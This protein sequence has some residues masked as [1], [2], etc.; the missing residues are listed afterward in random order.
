LRLHGNDVR[1]LILE[2]RVI[3][4]GML[5]A[6]AD[7]GVRDATHWNALRRKFPPTFFN[8][9]A[10]NGKAT[11]AEAL[12]LWNT[13]E[14]LLAVAPVSATSIAPGAAP[15]GP[16]VAALQAQVDSLTASL[17]AINFTGRGG[18]NQGN[19][20]GKPKNP[21]PRKDPKG[22]KNPKQQQNWYPFQGFYAPP[23]PYSP[24]APQYT[25]YAPPPPQFQQQQQQFQGGRGN[26]FRGR[27]NGRGTGRGQAQNNP[28]PA[29]QQ[30]QTQGQRSVFNPCFSCGATDH[31]R[32]DCPVYQAQLICSECGKAGHISMVCQSKN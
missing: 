18:G 31:L 1:R 11:V 9:L 2:Y 4:A 29:N 21:K 3:M 23:V 20:N 8:F 26:N 13:F 17:N 25:P 32:R 6:E 28:S 22:P 19:R 15:P 16:D 10:S 5:P 12:V 24:Y 27:G 14:P 7:L 30:L